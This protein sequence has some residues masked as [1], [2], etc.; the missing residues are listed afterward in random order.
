MVTAR[1][2]QGNGA[3]E[4]DGARQKI[5]VH[6]LAKHLLAEIIPYKSGANSDQ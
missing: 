2:R 3:V 4:R 6:Q 5:G 1:N